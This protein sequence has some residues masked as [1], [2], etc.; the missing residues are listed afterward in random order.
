MITRFIRVASALTLLALAASS[1]AAEKLPPRVNLVGLEALPGKIELAHA[2]DYRQLLV[3]GRT[4]AGELIDVTRMVQ[5][6]APESLVTISATGLVRPKENGEGELKLS[7]GGQSLAVPLSVRGLGSDYAVS[8][9]RDVMPTLSKVGCNAGTC[10]GAQEG[11]NGFKLSLRGYDPLFDHRALTD[12]LAGRRFNRAAP[13]HSLMLLKPA[14]VVPHVGGVLMKPGE[15]YYE[16]LRAWIASGVKLDLDSP[17]VASIELF[18]KNPVVALPGMKQQIVVMATYTD[19]S[20]RDVTQEA[21]VESSLAETVEADKTALATAV[22]RGEAAVLARYEGSYAATTITVMGDRSGYQ[23]PETP[24]HNYID[25][26]VYQKLQRVKILP[27]GLCTDAEFI[28]RVYLDLT[29]LPPLPEQVEAFLKDG[30][31]SRVKRDELIDRLVG[32]PDFIENWSNKWADLLQVNKKFLGDEGAW[33]FRNW[34]RQAMATNMPYD[35]FARAILTAGGSTLENPPAAYFKVLRT[36]EETMENTTQ[37]FLAIRFN[38]NKCHDHPFERWTQ[39]QYYQ[40]S[41]Y[42]AQVARKDDPAFAGKKIGGTAVE[43]AKPLVEV[44]YD[45]SSGDVTHLRTGVVTPPKFP[46]V[47]DDLPSTGEPRRQQLAH[48]LTS[49]D[50]PYFAKSYV[51]RIWSYLLGVGIIEPVDDIRA[52]NP[53]TNPDLLN[54][55]TEEFIASGFDVQQLFR[56]ICKSRAYQHSILTNKWNEDDEI[57]YSHAL[58][59]RLPAETLY[60]AVHIATGASI[61]LPGI[62]AGYRATQLLDSTDKLPDDFLGLFG[63]PPRESACECERSGGVILGQ[64]LNLVNGPT[65]AGAVH[66]PNNRIAKLAASAMDDKQ[67]VHDLFLSILCREPSEQELTAGLEALNSYEEEHQALIAAVEAYE[68]DVLPKRA[69]EWIKTARPA[70]EWSVLQPESL[71]SAGGATLTKQEEGSILVGGASP[72]TDTYTI[73]LKTPLEGIT[74]LKL[75]VLPDASLPAMGPG[76]APNGNFVLSVLRVNAASGSETK[77]VALQNAAAS[78]S[79]AN[80]SP[81]LAIDGNPAPKQGWAVCPEFGK[82][83]TALFE[84]KENLPAASTL[85]LVMEQGWGGQHTIG[86]FRLSATNA[87]RPVKLEGSQPSYPAEVTKVLSVPAAERTSEQQAQLADYY[88]STDAELAQLKQAVA[89]HEK[90]KGQGRLKGAQDLSWALINTPAFLFNR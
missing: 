14:G 8:F 13:D 50:N 67:L 71:A 87:P 56:T 44:V 7:L 61:K 75:E 19:G 70:V 65:I 32:G 42:F 9:V 36:P 77:P 85:T 84:T 18:P 38:C 41:G 73:T 47:H 20:V 17:R 83:H 43:G 76:R 45:T 72:A 59:R 90:Q 40:L 31:D 10:H 54:R 69:A 12:D 74:A 58:A 81:A 15:P 16:L 60:D 37:L 21:F 6:Q 88:R 68:K 55:M 89:E 86:R 80:F 34:I 57:N 66:D 28:R 49:Q 33:A 30:R 48:W 3:S 4:E 5:V 51:N 26:L 22:R 79:Q 1:Y 78:F 39:D 29:G 52:G 82:P 11:K 53:A 35:Q 25:K 24:E 46:F 64:A 2:Y 62:P 63:K 27:S 23:W